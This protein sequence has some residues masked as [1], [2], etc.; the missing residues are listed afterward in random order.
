MKLDPSTANPSVAPADL[1]VATGG[2]PLLRKESPAS[3]GHPGR[4]DGPAHGDRDKRHDQAGRRLVAVGA[5]FNAG[6][7]LA[8]SA[9]PRKKRIKQDAIAEI[10]ASGMPGGSSSSAALR[11]WR[12]SP[13]SS[14]NSG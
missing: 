11:T 5:A 3:P 8:S 6:L 9:V 12:R 1:I 10:Q 2:E 7:K 13:N 14:G 4:A